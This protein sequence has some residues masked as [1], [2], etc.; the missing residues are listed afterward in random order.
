MTFD[1]VNPHPA[2]GAE[3]CW[4]LSYTGI[5]GTPTLAHIHRSAPGYQR[6]DPGAVPAVPDSGLH[7]QPA[8]SPQ[9]PTLAQQIVDDPANFYVNVH[10]ADFPNGA[11]RGQL[12]AGPPPA[13]EAHLLPAPLRAYDSRDD[14]RRQDRASE[15]RTISLAN[16]MDGEGAS[17]IAVPR[18]PLRRSSR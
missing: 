4:D 11:I 10:T 8:A 17:V 15:T 6:P 12:S 5:T 7:R 16:G 18:E 3:V 14:R 1:I 2:T 9:T 13:G